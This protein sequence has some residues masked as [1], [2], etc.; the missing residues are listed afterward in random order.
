[1]KL[2]N[3]LC[4]RVWESPVLMTW[5]AS[6]IRSLNILVLLPV[7]VT[8][9][10]AA[11]IALWYIF[12]TLIQLQ[13][14]ADLG[15]SPTFVRSFAYAMGGAGV[16][17]LENPGRAPSSGKPDWDAVERIWGTSRMIYSRLT[18]GAAVGLALIGTPLVWEPIQATE[19]PREGLMAWASILFA[20]TVILR[21]NAYAAY[22]NGLDH[23]ALV[24]R[25][26]GL[27]NLG[28]I[29]SQVLVL[30]MGGGVFGL[31]VTHQSWMV[32]NV[33]RNRFL[34][35]YVSNRRLT[36]FTAPSDR[37]VFDSVWPRAW[38]SGV[39]SVMGNLPL[40]ATGLFYAQMAPPVD[41]A[42]YLVSL[43][44]LSAVRGFAMAP[45]Y[46]RLPLFARLRA[47]GRIRDLA[48]RSRR[49]M[50]WSYATLVFLLLT[51]GIGGGRIL[52]L[53]GA[54][55]GLVPVAIWTAFG[56]AF[57]VERFGAMHLHLFTTTNEVIWHTVN[58]STGA[59]MVVLA[60]GGYFTVG[61]VAF[62]LAMLIAYSLVYVPL[63]VPRS[64]ASIER[65][66][67]KFDVPIL[68]GPALILAVGMALA[69]AVQP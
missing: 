16:V 24:R 45:F 12:T 52:E 34:A 25:W 23:V 56:F 47:E 44:L 60:I 26:E 8:R 43:N 9:L 17:D 19:A 64:L 40:Q 3:E 15:F 46:S 55:T 68:A 53:L 39:G 33:V 57:L 62:P 38:R 41:A 36:R 13:L 48:E 21:G 29:G 69:V 5:G 35:R 22:L 49:G 58:G 6:A 1:M 51:F 61:V 11:E 10:D 30:L 18:W 4:R 65:R 66:F 27:M 28:A 42:R 20:S 59:V 7:V 37:R 14:L 63:V 32:L 31:A 67:S 2:V 50:A 54:N